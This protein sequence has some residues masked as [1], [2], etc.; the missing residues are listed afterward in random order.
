[1]AEVDWCVLRRQSE[2]LIEGYLVRI[3]GPLFKFQN[4]VWI[5]F[6]LHKLQLSVLLKLFPLLLCCVSGLLPE[7]FL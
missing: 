3:S 7:L 2:K 1:M 5:K 6:A 4:C